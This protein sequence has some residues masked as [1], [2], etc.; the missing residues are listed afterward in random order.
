VVGVGVLLGLVAGDRLTPGSVR[1]TIIT[2]DPDVASR[3]W[4]RGWPA[5]AH[6]AEGAQ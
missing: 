1:V 6:T 2:S 5:T 3:L 4:A